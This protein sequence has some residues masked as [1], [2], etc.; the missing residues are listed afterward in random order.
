MNENDLAT[1]P[2]SPDDSNTEIPYGYCECGCGRLT[3]LASCSNLER[4]WIRGEPLRFI[5]HHN[6]AVRRPPSRAEI[7]NDI[8]CRSIGLNED[9]ETFVDVSEYS[10]CMQFKWSASV[11]YREDGSVRSVYA[12]RKMR[13]ADG[14]Q[15]SQSL[16]RFITEM[17]DSKIQIDHIDRN[18]L[19]NFWKNF[20]IATP[21][22]QQHN[23][24]LRC[25]N[26]SG[27][28]GV[29]QLRG[30]EIW[31]AGIKLHGKKKNLGFF[32]TPED[33]ARAYDA[34]AVEAWGARACT[35]VMLGLLPPLDEVAL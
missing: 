9:Y 7:I 24:G 15:V 29:S 8:K 6:K 31:V 1:C 19:H 30:I 3:N 17:D 32:Y 11:R 12:V 23:T 22:Q 20:R 34:A 25:D 5:A 33:A 13:G 2:P 21:E 35:N 4:G 14:K 16:H 10:R 28:K 27:F 18:G 26:T